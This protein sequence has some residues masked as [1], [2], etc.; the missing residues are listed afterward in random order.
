M[1]TSDT[2]VVTPQRFAEGLDYPAYMDAV[3]VNK[4]RFESGYA[5]CRL[6]DADAQAFR[7][8]SARGG[9]PRKMLVLGEDW[10]GDVVRGLPV[11]ARIG[12]AAGMELRIFPR[13]SHH[14]IMNE[15][16]KN[17]QYMS[18]P[19]AVF[20][21]GDHQYIGHWIERPAIAETEMHQIEQDIRA[22]NP[23]IDDPAFGRERRA[24]F[25]SRVDGWIAATIVE[26]RELLERNAG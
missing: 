8:L 10:C 24:R 2:S 19:V 25:A 11:L 14:D 4:A 15:F 12:E 21:T 9:G 22:E 18:I 17:G 26:I 20:Y 5:E 1:T 6:S 3:K 13:D 23:D 16:L 7:E